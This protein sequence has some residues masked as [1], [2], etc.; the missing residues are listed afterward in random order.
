M[1]RFHG[2]HL[3]EQFGHFVTEGMTDAHTDRI[4]E[5]FT[6]ALDELMALGLL[7]P[8]DGT[9]PQGPGR[10]SESTESA[11]KAPIKDPAEL[12]PG[13]TE[14]WLAANFDPDARRAL[15]ESLLLELEGDAD[16]EALEASLIDVMKRHEAFRITFD[17][18][19]PLQSIAASVEPKVHRVDLSGNAD[20]QAALDK[21]CEESSGI[22]FDLDAPPLARVSV[23]K[24]GAKRAAVH[25]VVSHLIFDG[26]ASPVFVQDLAVAYRARRGGS[27]PLWK[28]EAESPRDLPLRNRSAGRE[29]RDAKL[30]STGS[31][32]CNLRPRCSRWVT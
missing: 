20:P 4:F 7:M 2:L 22:V 23:V 25:L 6:S 14:R 16:L 26:W 5:V 8:R 24:L 11:P 29:C 21:F 19:E 17:T 3:Y 9:P 15:N 10:K 27:A 30:R 32:R 12:S 31:A 28:S 18:A 1:T 13:Q